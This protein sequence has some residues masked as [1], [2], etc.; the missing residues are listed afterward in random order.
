M[1]SDVEIMDVAVKILKDGATNEAHEDFVRE[2]EIMSSFDHKNILHLLGV[3]V[4]GVHMLHGQS[5]DLQNQL[6]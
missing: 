6:S 3:V 2:V 1:K 4:K 5:G